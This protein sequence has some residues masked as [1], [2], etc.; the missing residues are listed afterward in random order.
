[1]QS[2]KNNNSLEER[3]VFLKYDSEGNPLEVSKAKGTHISYVY[4]YDKKYPVAKIENATYAQVVATGVNLS[5]LDDVSST[6]AAKTVELNKIRNGL[7]S[8]MV[9]TYTY[10]PLIG[11]TS[12]TDPRGYT[13]YYTY[14]NFN[15][16]KEVRDQNNKLLSEN[17]YHYKNQ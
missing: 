3:I 12:M 13:I 15:R 1:V 7:S 6:E 4:G 10:D 16:L 5:I 14:D 11:V 9:S 17:Q 2:S 8:A